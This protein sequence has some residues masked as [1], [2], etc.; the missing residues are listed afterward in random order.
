L[1][2]K[3]SEKIDDLKAAKFASPDYKGEE[4]SSPNHDG[5]KNDVTTGDTIQN[6]DEEGASQDD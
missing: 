1:V 2:A 6:E 3:L 4:N 5:G